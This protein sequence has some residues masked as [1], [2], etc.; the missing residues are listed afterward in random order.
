MI[1]YYGTKDERRNS[2]EMNK[3]MAIGGPRFAM[4]KAA[5]RRKGRS[6]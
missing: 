3:R 1:K 5:T 6:N 2:K 4:M